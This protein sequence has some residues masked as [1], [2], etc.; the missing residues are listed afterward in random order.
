VDDDLDAARDQIR[1]VL[2]LYIGGMGARGRNFY[3]DL[4][5]RYGFEEAAAT[6]QDHY[7]DGRKAEATAAVPDELVDEVALVGPMGRVRDR[8][9]AWKESRVDVLCLGTHDPRVLEELQAAL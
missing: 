9:E 3:N 5:R 7:L 4:A 8:L 1:P 2:A 6:I